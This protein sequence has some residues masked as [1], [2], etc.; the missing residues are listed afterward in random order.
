MLETT[1]KTHIYKNSQ[2]CSRKEEAVVNYKR[3]EA[4][5]VNKCK[6]VL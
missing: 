3:L 4:I 2:F 6:E 5:K 1:V